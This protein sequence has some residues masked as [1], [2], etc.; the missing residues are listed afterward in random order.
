[1]EVPLLSLVLLIA[2]S[3]QQ[4][5]QLILA[6]ATPGSYHP[7]AI[8]HNLSL[9]YLLLHSVS[10]P[11]RRCRAIFFTSRTKCHRC[12]VIFRTHPQH[13]TPRTN[14]LRQVRGSKP[15]DLVPELPLSSA[16][17][18]YSESSNW[19]NSVSFRGGIFSPPCCSIDVQC[20]YVAATALSNNLG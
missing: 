3:L 20:V 15:A 6:I 19:L 5:T 13:C 4:I 14:S 1:M 16:F 8:L 11:C 12:R 9:L 7:L 18:Q 2:I 17:N 10:L